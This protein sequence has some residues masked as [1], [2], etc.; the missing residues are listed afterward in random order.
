MDPTTLI[1]RD[2]LLSYE[3]PNSGSMSGDEKDPH[4]FAYW[5]ATLKEDALR[6]LFPLLMTAADDDAGRVALGVLGRLRDLLRFYEVPSRVPDP[7]HVKAWISAIEER[8]LRRAD[9]LRLGGALWV[10][11]TRGSGAASI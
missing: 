9:D 6:Y 7:D 8:L 11:L 2:V 1:D 4:R 10:A 5:V 3:G